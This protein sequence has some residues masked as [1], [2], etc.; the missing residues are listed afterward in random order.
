MA[1]AREGRPS[2]RI[3]V[4]SEVA[5]TAELAVLFGMPSREGPESTALPGVW[6][7]WVSAADVGAPSSE[8]QLLW[9]LVQ[10]RLSRIRLVGEENVVRLIV[11]CRFD[12]S[13]KQFDLEP[14]WVALLAEAGASVAIDHGSAF[15]DADLA[16]V[17]SPGGDDSVHPAYAIDMRRLVF[18]DAL[19]ASVSGLR[20]HL[21]EHVES[22][23]GL[24][25]TM[26]FRELIDRLEA[27]AG[28]EG[29]AA[30]IIS[31]LALYLDAQRR[32]GDEFTRQMIDYAILVELPE[33][34]RIAR[35]LPPDLA[36]ARVSAIRYP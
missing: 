36:R 31:G 14:E 18:V 17:V 35:A 6:K 30:E 5:S 9:P 19:C 26:F 7:L 33:S 23:E 8:L 34:G 32:S 11:D 15:D 29:A 3:V 20:A 12:D 24:N 2:V 25:P 22:W 10:G 21:D 28:T 1:V 13:L 27:R 4:V 16:R